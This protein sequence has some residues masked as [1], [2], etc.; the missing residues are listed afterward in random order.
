VRAARPARATRLASRE[1]SRCRS[2]LSDEEGSRGLGFE[3]G[4]N[5][6]HPRAPPTLALVHDVVATGEGPGD[7]DLRDGRFLG[8]WTPRSAAY[9]ASWCSRRATMAKAADG[10][11]AEVDSV[12]EGCL[13]FR[14]HPKPL[15]QYDLRHAFQPVTDVANV[16]RQ[17]YFSLTAAREMLST[18]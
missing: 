9:A 10:T 7:R 17:F 1:A 4:R 6:R 13:L 3:T 2:G 18:P 12:F 15:A 14:Q 16:L 5:E 8:A 11:C